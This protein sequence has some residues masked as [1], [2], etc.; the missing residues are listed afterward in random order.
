[1]DK[2][3]RFERFSVD[4]SMFGVLKLWIYWCWIFENFFV[5]LMEEGFDKFGVLINFI[6]FVVFEY[7]EECVDYE[8]VIEI[9]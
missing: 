9:F 8:F 2:V 5:V 6:L 7:V 1:M 4:L 3:F